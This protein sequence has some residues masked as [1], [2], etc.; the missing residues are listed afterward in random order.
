[1][2]PRLRL[3]PPRADVRLGPCPY[4]Y[5]GGRMGPVYRHRRRVWVGVHRAVRPRINHDQRVTN[6]RLYQT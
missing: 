4:A 6:A 2:V 3:R 5:P 1:M